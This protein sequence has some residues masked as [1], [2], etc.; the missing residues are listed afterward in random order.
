MLIRPASYLRRWR[1]PFS[2][3]LA[4]LGLC[5]LTGG[6]FSQRSTAEESAAAEEKN[7]QQQESA[8]PPAAA[9]KVDFVRDVA[10]LF[11]QHC[12]HCHGPDEQEG[13]LRLDSKKVV[14]KGGQSGPALVP[15]KGA[16]S[17]LL[18]RL[19]GLGDHEQMP[20]DADPLSDKQIGLVRAWIE[21]GAP[22]PDDFG[23]QDD[24]VAKH[25]AYQQPEKPAL[26]SVSGESW[27][28]NAI[29][30]FVLSRLERE[31]IAPSPDAD[32][33]ALLRRVSLDL[34]GLPPTP[35][36][37]E[38]FLADQSDKAYE[39]VVDRLLASPQYGERW[40]R[41]WLDLVRY[42]DT[43]G[44][45]ADQFR[46]IW[47]YRDWVIDAINRD[48][49]YDQFTI[50]QIAGD[51][52]PEPTL[53]QRVATGMHRATTCNVEAGVD[54]E[55]NRVNQII[56]R[57][58]VTGTVWLGTTVECTQCHNHKYDPF[59]QEDFYRLFAFFNN[60]PLEVKL[61]SGVQYNFYGPTMELPLTEQERQQK[62]ALQAR[63]AELAAQLNQAQQQAEAAQD[64]WE[65]QLAK[66]LAEAPR[67][68][69]LTPQSFASS[70]G[71]AHEVR[72]DGSVLLSGKTPDEDTYTVR[73]RANIEGITGFRIE[74]LTD[75]SLP[76]TG[77]GRQ[78]VRP[79]F[80]LTDLQVTAAK[81]GEEPAAVPLVD[82]HADYAAKGFEPDKAVDDDPKTGW[83]IHAQFGKPHQVTYR[84]TAPLGNA[85]GT[86]LVFQLRQNYGTGRT[87]GRL[88]ISAVT[89]NFGH[90]KLPAPVA[91]ALRVPAG[92]RSAKEKKTVRDHYLAQQPQL[93]HLRE[94]LAEV[95]KQSDAIAPAT[96]LVMVEMRIFKRG[97]FLDPG[98]QVEPGAPRVLHELPQDAPRNRLGLA[99][100]LVSRENPLTARVAVNRWWAEIFGRG[101]VATLED[102]G[103]QGDAPTHP[104]L[105]DWLAVEFMDS[106]WSM[107]HMHK[108]MVMSRTY[109]Q[110]SQIRSSLQASD[111]YNRL[112]ARAARFRLP[113]ET[114]RDNAL[115]IS[116]LLS[117]EMGGPPIY[118]PQPSNIWRHVGRNA[119]KYLTSS[120][121]DRFRRGIY[122]V[123]RRSAPYPSFVN[124]D[125]P[126]RSACTVERPRTNTPLQALTLLNDP[127]YV[128]MTRALARRVV[129]EKSAA[130]LA[131]QV[132]YA[133][134]LCVARE[135]T[136]REQK[137][138]LDI[139]RREFARFSKD[140]AA[141]GQLYENAKFA[142][143]AEAAQL[144]AWYFLANILLNLDETIT[145]G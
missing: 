37:V 99:Q 118:P 107:K 137:L 138:L 131:E 80:V 41:Q 88:R 5:L 74:A 17:I 32:K 38:A 30:Y 76:K 108:L 65:A 73:F 79:N 12:Y 87:I 145:R 43:N 104:G 34:T 93:A 7:A 20:P 28:A 23:S 90:S 35:Q 8:L 3:G 101:L 51:L 26:P 72:D 119:P 127:A 53:A 120:G 15:G 4:C 6:L 140:P 21:Q 63:Q 48:L 112:L 82:G 46:E 78:P 130:S 42:A 128:E 89:G 129:A 2:R 123:W 142:S 109:R 40:A 66:T 59:T 114:I 77:P 133:F 27:P 60:T 117:K 132:R 71:A 44:Y 47:A 52:L 61:N 13:L 141:A 113:A 1:L 57:V 105:L 102:F 16:E 115:A 14:F 95:K 126:D 111:P 36:Q 58:N 144:G 86:D 110:S 29:D 84:T 67:W 134:R 125:A 25:W 24:Y 92:K 19:A 122:V 11:A 18:Q 50:D 64:E 62:Q 54:P 22:W 135:P 69:V 100:W 31:A 45:Q 96:T 136:D 70:G 10:P 39:N 91:A 98:R 143:D 121:N 116:G 81:E 55:E 49:P 124:F 85:G 33:A 106:G 83:A 103:T 97:S 75:P 68:H 9:G 139:Y 56:D 94:Q